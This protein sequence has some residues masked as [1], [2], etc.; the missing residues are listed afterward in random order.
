MN[1]GEEIWDALVELEKKFWNREDYSEEDV[2]LLSD[3]I[4]YIESDREDFV[5]YFNGEL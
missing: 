5:R 3:V 1:K 2:T 4:D